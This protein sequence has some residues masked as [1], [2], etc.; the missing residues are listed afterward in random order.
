LLLQNKADASIANDRGATAEDWARQTGNTNIADILRQASAQTREA[1]EQAR[2]ARDQAREAR[3]Q[4]AAAE[5]ETE[6]IDTE[7]ETEP[8]K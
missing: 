2:K 8:S 4:A 6:L 7:A 1:R 5:L 3:E